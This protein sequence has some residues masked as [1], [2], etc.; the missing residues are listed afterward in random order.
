M[1]L[2]LVVQCRCLSGCGWI[3]RLLMLSLTGDWQ[4]GAWQVTR[5]LSRTCIRM[6]TKGLKAIQGI[7]GQT[8][9]LP[10]ST[11]AFLDQ[12]A[13]KR[14][15]PYMMCRS[16]ADHQQHIYKAQIRCMHNVPCSV[17]HDACCM[18]VHGCLFSMIFITVAQVL[19][20][21]AVSR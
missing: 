4:T 10:W 8:S 3:A 15:L 1:G 12:T 16:T 5:A 13:C 11:A 7:F 2:C 6:G 19:Q 14:Q 17:M 21:P 9:L 18:L 20:V